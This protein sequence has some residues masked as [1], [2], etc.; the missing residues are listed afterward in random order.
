MHLT[1]GF[2]TPNVELVQ[3]SSTYKRCWHGRF[4]ETSFIW[5]TG[6]NWSSLVSCVSVTGLPCGSD[7]T[8]RDWRGQT[9]AGSYSGGRGGFTL[10]TE[11]GSV[12]VGGM[13]HSVTCHLWRSSEKCNPTLNAEQSSLSG[14]SL[15]HLNEERNLRC[16]TVLLSI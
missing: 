16:N 6:V 5:K 9:G 4:S 7:R 1:A 13:G 8:V 11:L 3:R 10:R 2:V 14:I 12:S 15:R